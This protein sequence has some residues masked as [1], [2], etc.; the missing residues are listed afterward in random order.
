VEEV[1]TYAVRQALQQQRHA[2]MRLLPMT[3]LLLLLLQV[4][5]VQWSYLVPACWVQQQQ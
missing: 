1:L 2:R 3:L 4:V 5:L